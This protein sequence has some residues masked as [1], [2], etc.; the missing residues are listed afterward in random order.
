MTSW[1]VARLE[2]EDEPAYEALVAG[3]P[4]FHT[5]RF[6]DALAA[7]AIGE[8]V[9]WVGRRQGRV[10]AALPAFV[11]RGGRGA[12]LNSLPF[13]QSPGGVIGAGDRAEVAPLLIGA[14]LEHCA[15][16]AIDVACVIGNPYRPIEDD[17]ALFP[18]RPDFKLVRTTHVLDLGAPFAPRPSTQWTVRKV[19]RLGP[20]HR[21]AAGEAEARVAWQLYAAS[22]EGLG[23]RPHPF[24]LLAA[25]GARFV[26]AEVD[27]R[28]L[29]SLILLEH[30]QISD[31]YC[32][33]NS[34]EGRRLQVGSWLCQRELDRARA[35]GVRLWNWGVSPSPAVHDFKKRW[36]GRDRAYAIWGWCLGDVSAWQR[37]TP[38]AL[39]AEFPHYFVLPYDRLQPS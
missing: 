4:L 34:E 14:M 35:A 21:V 8:P 12:V 38:A 19:E 18:R 31:Y 33:G 3:G 5:L 23:V 11:R 17:E 6:R 2:G 9:Y 29:S 1:E 13:V 22:M 16:Q 30:G 32:V 36:G 25:A 27:G 26:W 7:H 39:A 28:P 20:Q 15:R 37:L 24:S 10:G